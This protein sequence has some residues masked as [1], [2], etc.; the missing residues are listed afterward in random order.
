MRFD[1][2]GEPSAAL[3]CRLVGLV[4]QHDLEAPDLEI[5]TVAGCMEMRLEIEEMGGA[6]GAI[7]AQKMARC[8]GVEAVALDGVPV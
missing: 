7:L 4:A 6:V 2:V 3:V 8:I 5:R 1:I